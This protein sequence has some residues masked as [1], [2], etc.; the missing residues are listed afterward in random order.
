MNPTSY[1]LLFAAMIASAAFVSAQSS[2]ACGQ[3]F[4]GPSTG[5]CCDPKLGC[6]CY[7]TATSVCT[8]IIGG[9]GAQ[10]LCGLQDN[11][12]LDVVVGDTCFNKNTHQC[13]PVQGVNTNSFR[14]CPV[15]TSACGVSAHCFE[16]NKY[17]CCNGAI[18]Q[19]GQSNCNC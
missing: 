8:H 7:S 18:C 4:C 6:L 15:G 14:V 2:V 1:L 10:K 9:F 19:I 3:F 13:V 5:C 11:A 16:T 12:C 17:K